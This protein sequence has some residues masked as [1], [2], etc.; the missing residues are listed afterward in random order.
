MVFFQENTDTGVGSLPVKC[1]DAITTDRSI[2][3]NE[4]EVVVTE[5]D[6]CSRYIRGVFYP[7][8][9]RHHNDEMLDDGIATLAGGCQSHLVT[10]IKCVVSV[11]L[12]S[13]VIDKDEVRKTLYE[14]SIKPRIPNKWADMA[15]H[16]L[17]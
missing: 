10:G 12:V 13:Y 14:W 15:I 3:V 4:E 1:R 17:P 6:Y 7:E 16:V 9:A 2:A 11:E 5:I 8:M